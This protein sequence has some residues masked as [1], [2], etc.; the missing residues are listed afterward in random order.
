[1]QKGNL[2]PYWREKLSALGS[3]GQQYSRPLSKGIIRRTDINVCGSLPV[4]LLTMTSDI[5]T[6]KV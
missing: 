6:G 1:M 2:T 5:L 4:T 3:V